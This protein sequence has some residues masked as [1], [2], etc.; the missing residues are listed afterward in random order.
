MAADVLA[1][2]HTLVRLGTTTH[3]MQRALSNT[4]VLMAGRLAALQRRAVRRISHTGGPTQPAS[5]R[6]A[7]RPRSGR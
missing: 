3:R 5:S 2:T 7:A 1:L 6:I 4:L